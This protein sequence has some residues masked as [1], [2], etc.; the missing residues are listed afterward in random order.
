MKKIS[1]LGS[2]GSIGQ[3]TLAIVD[4]FPNDFEVFAISCHR[5]LKRF[6]AQVA[7]YKPKM[8]II[9]DPEAYQ[10]AAALKIQYPSTQ[11][12]SGREGLIEAVSHE[13]VQSVVIAI[14]GN[15]ALLP[16]IAAIEARKRVCIANK[17]VLVTSGHI[18]MPLAAEKNVELIP[19]DSEHS[20]LF[21]ALQGNEKSSIEKVILTASGGPFRGMKRSE[22]VDKTARE[23][24]KHPKWDMGQKI[25][26]DSATLMNKGL[27]VI[28]A[29]WLFDLKPEQIDVVVH[30]QS[31]IHSLIQYQDSSVMAQMGLPDMRL[32]IVYALNYP[33]RKATSLERMDLAALMTLTFERA[34]KETF[35]CLEL[36]Y[37][38]LRA[39]GL[40]PTILNAANEVLVARYL[41]NEI[42]FY[43]I[44]AGIE[45]ALAQC[46]NTQNPTL[47]NVLE[48]DLETRLR[49][50]KWQPTQRSRFR[51]TCFDG[52]GW[53]RHSIYGMG[54]PW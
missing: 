4:E 6:E 45:W 47:E 7:K 38:V 19:V 35:P 50:A 27:E 12:L 22:L 24:L 44:P 31:I 40:Q 1:I 18:I 5:D 21:Q 46:G 36:A 54:V 34:D 29:K 17:E 43:D 11:F 48:S 3:Q 37:E 53:Q 2:T 33:T 13:A 30:P 25:S 42:G 16:T 49:T 23:A 20:A 28:E 10:S 26:I 15:D 14:V 51:T 8:A 32:P 52:Y 41:A 9:T 39:G